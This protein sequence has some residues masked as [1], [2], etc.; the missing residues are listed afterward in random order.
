MTGSGGPSFGTCIDSQLYLLLLILFS[1]LRH[2][3]F[4]LKFAFELFLLFFLE[5]FFFFSRRSLFSDSAQ[6]AFFPLEPLR[7]NLKSG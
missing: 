6:A 3:D 1:L 2:L 7:C 5:D 4:K